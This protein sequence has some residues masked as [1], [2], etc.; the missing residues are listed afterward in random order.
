MNIDLPLISEV[1]YTDCKQVDFIRQGTNLDSV[2][3]AN[4]FL[5]LHR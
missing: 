4:K 3:K 5:F 2:T 1:F